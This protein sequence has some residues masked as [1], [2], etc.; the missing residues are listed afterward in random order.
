MQNTI[1]AF[2]A[3]PLSS[4]MISEIEKI[5]KKLKPLCPN[6]VRWVD[7]HGIHLTLKFLGDIPKIKIPQINTAMNQVTKGERPFQFEARGLGAFPRPQQARVLWIGLEKSIQL[8]TLQK[9]LEQKLNLIGFPV[10]KRVF[11]PH[12]TIAR[13]KDQASPA[14]QR[15]ISEILFQNQIGSLGNLEVN[16]LIMFQSELR[17][18]GAVYSKLFTADFG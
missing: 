3:V 4:G 15:K 10:D 16:K 5:I 8:N 18:V 14:E 6:N 1:R 12:L 13:I 7:T 17:P 11:N 9:E 2:I